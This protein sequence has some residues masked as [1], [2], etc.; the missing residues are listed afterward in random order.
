MHCSGAP[1]HCIH[2][3]GS[4]ELDPAH[5]WAHSWLDHSFD[6]LLPWRPHTKDTSLPPSALLP[7][8]T[9]SHC[10]QNNALLTR[11]SRRTTS[12]ERCSGAEQAFV[13]ASSWAPPERENHTSSAPSSTCSLSVTRHTP[14]AAFG[15]RTHRYCRS[16]HSRV[17][18]FLV[19]VSVERER[20]R[21]PTAHSSELF[22]RRPPTHHQRILLYGATPRPATTNTLPHDFI[23]STL[24]SSSIN[25]SDRQG[26]TTCRSVSGTTSLAP[27]TAKANEAD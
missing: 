23:C 5:H 27:P 9:S 12:S 8:L 11:L 15:D 2:L 3:L 19:A 26:A 22:E 13:H 14:F 1:L 18:Y 21:C 24:L 16:K 7:Q 4:R 17:N 25:L 6:R 10:R 20:H